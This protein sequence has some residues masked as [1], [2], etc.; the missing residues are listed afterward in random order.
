MKKIIP[1]CLLFC[2]SS[3][4][5]QL[6][7]KRQTEYG[8]D[9]D[10]K[11]PI[12]YD[13]FLSYAAE[14]NKPQLNFILNVQNDLFQFTKVENIYQASYHISL[15]IKKDGSDAA[16]FSR[17]WQQSVEE[18]VFERTNS[19]KI[20]QHNQNKIEMDVS[21]GNYK[22]FLEVTDDGT[23]KGYHNAR[24]LTVPEIEPGEMMHTQIKLLDPV[25][26][27]SSE[28]ILEMRDPMVE[29]NHDLTAYF[30]LQTDARDS[31]IITS[32]LS[33]INDESRA[34]QRQKIYRFLP[35]T[36]LLQFRE[37][38]GKNF[39]PEGKFVLRYRIRYGERILEI[40]KKFEVIWFDKP[41]YLYRYDLAI[42]PMQYVL[43]QAEWNTADAL[44]Y[45]ELGIW[46]NA[47]WK[48]KDPSPETPF[49]EIMYTF[50]HRVD[51]VNRIYGQRFKEGWETDRGKSY[52]LYGKPDRQEINR[53]SVNAKPYEVWYYDALK[54][55]L[56]FID[57]YDDEDYKLVQI[58]EIKDSKNE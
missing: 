43:N 22:L 47:Y 17:V 56:T 11:P 42:R 57:E 55:K 39:L 53:T 50:F 21:P 3:I 27:A 8:F 18:K 6:P 36:P 20:Y 51:E 35:I 33:Q 30:E 25:T 26:D 52:L 4:Y 14:G 2:Y 38:L 28:V 9:I 19:K 34:I 54:Q 29:F 49:N 12:Y 13:Y 37:K 58:E 5:A 45:D 23:M 31:L 7:G 46:F 48:K 32:K 24:L 41:V 10:Y 1:V 15:T 16:V 40:E 44:S